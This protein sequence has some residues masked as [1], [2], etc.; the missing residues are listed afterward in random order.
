[1]FF[2]ETTILRDGYPVRKRQ[3]YRRNIR[4]GIVSIEFNNTTNPPDFLAD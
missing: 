2:D 4:N 3:I 1:M